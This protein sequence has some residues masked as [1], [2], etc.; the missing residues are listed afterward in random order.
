MEYDFIIN[1]ILLFKP[2]ISKQTGYE[3]E[4]ESLRKEAELYYKSEASSTFLDPRLQREGPMNSLSS[5]RL[6]VRL[7]VRNAKFSGLVH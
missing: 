3:W 2:W 4:S 5:V 6:S 1:Y 7:S